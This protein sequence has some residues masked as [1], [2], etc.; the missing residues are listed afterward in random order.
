MKKDKHIHVGVSWEAPEPVNSAPG[1]PPAQPPMPGASMKP[2]AFWGRSRPALPR[3]SPEPVKVLPGQIDRRR[4][5][6]K[7]D[8][9][10]G[11]K[12]ITVLILTG[13]LL[14][15]LLST[16]A[17]AVLW[18][19]AVIRAQPWELQTIIGAALAGSGVRI[20]M[21]REEIANIVRVK[22]GS[23]WRWTQSLT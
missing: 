8:P 2:P 11:W 15:A 16:I 5:L 1:I 22:A 21:E 20:Y 19:W 14:L 3:K 6:G 7:A 12:Q 17:F 4:V 23:H 18:V 9:P 13:V 10:Q